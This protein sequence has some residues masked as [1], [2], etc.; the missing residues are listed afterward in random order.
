MRRSLRELIA[1]TLLIALNF[2]AAAHAA[3]KP[4]PLSLRVLSSRPDM[5]SGE[6]A[7]I[8]VRGPSKGVR[9]TLN[10]RDV[11]G[12]LR[13]DPATRTLRGLITGLALGKNTLGATAGAA[14]ASLTL[15]DY[16]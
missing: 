9:L 6:D 12:D 15:T 11:S 4:A 8:E 16:P 7:L 14:K 10:G 3:D 1:T 13:L 2:A 5:I